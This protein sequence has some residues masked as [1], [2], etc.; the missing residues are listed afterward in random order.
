MNPRHVSLSKGTRLA[1]LL[2]IVA[3]LSAASESTASA[4]TA[5]YDF[6]VGFGWAGQPLRFIAPREDLPYFAKFPPVYYGDLVRRPYGFSPYALP[7]GIEPVEQRIVEQRMGPR[8]IM[9]PFFE[10]CPAPSVAPAADAAPAT[11]IA[12]SEAPAVETPETE[13]VRPV[14]DSDIA[15]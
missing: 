10:A 5:G 15:T 7:P 2:A 4:Q 6:G 8:T 14:E 11:D 3:A 1:G 9:N 13:A 12:P